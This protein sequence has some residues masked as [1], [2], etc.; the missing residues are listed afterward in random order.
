MATAR[1]LPSIWLQNS[2][3][4]ITNLRLNQHL[5]KKIQSAARKTLLLLPG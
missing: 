2:I 1:K 3:K 4:I 5:K